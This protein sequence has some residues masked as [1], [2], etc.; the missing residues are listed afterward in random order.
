MD[1][2]SPESTGHIQLTR[3]S[4]T[5][6]FL[7]HTEVVVSRPLEEVF[8]FFADAINL[9]SIT[10]D[11]LRCRILTPPPIAMAMGTRIDYALRLRGI[12]LPWTSQIVE[13]D[14]PR[15]F[16]D[17]Q[18]RGPFHHWSHE[19]RFVRVQTSGGVDATLIA[20]RVTYRVF[21]GAIV[22]R[23]FVARELRAI[24]TFRQRRIQ[25]FFA[26]YRPGGRAVRSE[27]SGQNQN[28]SGTL[29]GAA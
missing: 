25:E 8:P 3:D 6:C 5:G 10:P 27:S 4:A 23:L 11:N 19:H 16:V 7:L 20:D 22:N 17:V 1:V 15:R 24:F 26:E 29:S 28:R 21:G 18:I 2:R 9:D 14:P 12:P 13:W